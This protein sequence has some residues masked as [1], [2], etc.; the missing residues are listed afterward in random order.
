MMI[1]KNV[2]LVGLKNIVCACQGEGGEYG[3]ISYG[4][5]RGCQ[6][7]DDDEKKL[8]QNDWYELGFRVL[9]AVV[10]RDIAD[11]DIEN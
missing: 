7:D 2:F 6:D 8:F 11:W 5:V 4:D 9:C 1:L 10:V 3:R